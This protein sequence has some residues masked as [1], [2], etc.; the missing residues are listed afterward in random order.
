MSKKNGN[1]AY[2]KL[3]LLCLVMIIKNESKIIRRCFDAVRPYIDYWCIFDTGSIDGTQDIV[4]QYWKKYGIPGELRE[5]KWQDFMH[6]R[7]LIVRYAVNKARW[8]WLIDAD[9][10]VDVQ[11]PLFLSRLQKAPPKIHSYYHTQKNDTLKYDRPLLVRADP[12]YEWC[13]KKRTHEYLHGTGIGAHSDM[14]NV[15]VIHM[16]DGGSKSDKFIR[17]EKLLALDIQDS[18]NDPRGYFYMAETKRNM[19]KYNEAIAFYSK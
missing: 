10:V 15:F 5:D 9:D 2:N 19:G 12:K 8:L 1:Q 3:P 7:T 17:D 6:N 18:P 11:N 13:Y 16:G 4:R 14:P